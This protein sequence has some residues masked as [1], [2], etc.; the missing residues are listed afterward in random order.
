MARAGKMYRV[1]QAGPR[2]PAV[3]GPVVQLGVR[4]HSAIV[5]LQIADE[6]AR[7]YRSGLAMCE[8]SNIATPSSE[9][10][11]FPLSY[12][13]KTSNFPVPKGSAA[14]LWRRGL[15]SSHSRLSNL[16]G[17]TAT[18][19]CETEKLRHN[20]ALWG[21]A[22]CMQTAASGA[23]LV[24]ARSCSNSTRNRVVSRLSSPR[25][26]IVSYC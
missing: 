22:L 26:K 6:Q 14:K 7:A 16:A 17:V 12:S 25:W 4:P 13:I 18:P 11:V 24:D 8:D 23:H 1:P 21:S 5:I 2:R 3:A 15:L 10:L 19:S 20:R 9:N